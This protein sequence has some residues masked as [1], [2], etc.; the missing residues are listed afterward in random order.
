MQQASETTFTRR[1]GNEFLL[2]T[3][4]HIDS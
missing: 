4:L 1:A 2:L 3:F